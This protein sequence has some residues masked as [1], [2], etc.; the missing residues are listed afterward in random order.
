MD[1][2]YSHRSGRIET[3]AMNRELEAAITIGDPTELG[4]EQ[5]VAGPIP[6]N[7]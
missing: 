5:S 6:A 1:T 4:P 3:P 2:E 7:A